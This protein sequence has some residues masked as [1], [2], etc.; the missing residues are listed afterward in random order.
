MNAF[1][2][3]SF[4]NEVL[5]L[6]EDSW[7]FQSAVE[8]TEKQEEKGRKLREKE[9][10]QNISKEKKY[11]SPWGTAPQKCFTIAE[12]K[13]NSEIQYITVHK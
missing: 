12:H 11:I 3:L 7:I 4:S 6:E 8:E 2:F 5:F 13:I 1:D 10:S 9:V